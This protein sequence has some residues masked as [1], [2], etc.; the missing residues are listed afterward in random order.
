MALLIF[1]WGFTIFSFVKLP[2]TIPIHF[3]A[4]GRPDNYGNKLT[5]FLLPVIGSI[6]Y[7]G[8]TY[9]NK[10]PRVFNYKVQ[11]TE[12]NAESQYSFATRM[13]RILKFSIMLIFSLIVLYSY[14]T[15]IGHTKAPGRWFLPLILG[16][17]SIPLIYLVIKSLRVQKKSSISGEI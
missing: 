1:L 9:L 5:L 3:D 7:A 10:Y 17:I 2:E 13:L 4:S 8:I 16:I 15:A 11:I 6:I 12:E 14:W